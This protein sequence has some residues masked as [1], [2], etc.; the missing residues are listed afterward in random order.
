MRNA[1]PIESPTDPFASVPLPTS[2]V[3]KKPRIEGLPPGVSR[4]IFGPPERQE[5]R[6]AQAPSAAGGPSNGALPPAP[7]PAQPWPMAGKDSGSPAPAFGGQSPRESPPAFEP[8]PR[9]RRLLPGLLTLLLVIGV[10]SYVVPAVLMSG[11]VLRGTRV[12]GVDIGG[13]TVTQA[14]DKLRTELATQLSK[15]V[16]ADIGG[17][18]DTIQPDEA[19]LELDV[20]GT[21]GQAPSG[22]PSP[23]EVWRGLTG[24]TDLEPKINI[25]TS[26]LTRTVEGLAE[27]VDKR[28]Q[29]GR[30]AFSGL[31]PRARQPED[32]VLLDRDDAVKRIGD[33][34]LR[35]GGAVVLTLR[36]SKP[37]TTPGAVRAA[38]T[39]AK[40]AVAAPITLTLDGKQAQ[41]PP[42]AIAA[43]LSF[44]S[45]GS[46]GLAP[47]FDAK[48]VLADVESDLVSAAQQPRDA[49]Y[50]IVNG[51]A[52][53]VPARTG[54]GVNDKLL[55]R[56][57]EKV[58]A[59]G[60][61]RTIPVR[62]GTV[63][64]EVATS[65]IRGL[66]I[67]ETL[68]TFTTNFACCQ[69]RAKNIQRMA[70]ELDGHIVKPGETFSINDVVG[71]RTVEDGYAEAAE[72]VGGRLV[73]IVGGGVSQ[74]A[75]TM[76][77]A[78]YFSGLED[79]EHKP[80]DYYTD[81]FPAGRD[82]ALLYPETDLKWR[83]DS[84]NGVL[85]K[86]AST[87]TSVT[88]ALWGVKR[89][90]KIEA[91][92]SERRDFTQF[93]RETSNAPGCLPTTGAQGFT[94]DV[95]RVF[96]KD[97][98]VVKKDDKLT[99]KYRPQPQTTCTAS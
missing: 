64:P 96:H 90:D 63:A 46:G 75:T 65:E 36:P 99:T 13:L 34:F 73:N 2:S 48:A 40:R 12:S 19:G 52:V 15:P 81:Q 24:T 82:V 87:Q 39:K 61:E 20:V 23:Q 91:V 5:S 42:A 32:G 29:E 86:T 44:A 45:D 71:E 69:P 54:R 28:A 10:L 57:A 62:L 30:V 18:K 72:T 93:R 58:F 33:A 68:A 41:V 43:N 94:I 77:N 37:V 26:Q 21:I 83:N 59:E 8:E 95:M 76:Y 88:V 31:T 27:S 7:P 98:R 84:D 4:D 25:D 49:T 35:G 14:A 74:F 80:M 55:A 50:E 70:E 56:D 9:R 1:G 17:K 22:F 78:A 85:I 16:I 47:Q 79:V 6:P 92:E 3:S 89:Y 53:L 38:L 51:K 66:G 67:K 60:G 97:G 11:S